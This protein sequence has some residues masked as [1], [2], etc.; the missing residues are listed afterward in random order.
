MAVATKGEAMNVICRQCGVPYDDAERSTVCP[1]DRFLTVA[2]QRQKDLALSLMGKDL[3]WAHR[4]SMD[5]I[6]RVE[7]ISWTGMVTIRGFVGEFAP[8]LFVV[9]PPSPVGVEAGRA[10]YDESKR[11]LLSSEHLP[12]ERAMD[13]KDKIEDLFTYHKPEGNQPAQY[14]A[15][16]AKAKELAHVIVENTPASADQTAAIRKLRE[17]VMTANASIALKGIG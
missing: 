16:R 7:S 1:H 6:V 3:R 17:C 12:K 10:Y 8:H 4:P 2:V 14:E 11:L 15:I 9:A 13:L 5:D